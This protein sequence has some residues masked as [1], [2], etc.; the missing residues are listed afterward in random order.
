MLSW[1]FQSNAHIRDGSISVLVLLLAGAALLC[2][3]LR[4]VHHRMEGL[5]E[6]RS[7]AARHRVAIASGLHDGQLN[8]RQTARAATLL[9][10]SGSLALQLALGALAVRWLHALVVAFK[11]LAHRRATGF[12][13]GA[14]GV[15]LSRRAHGLAFRAVF[16]L[17]VVLRAADRAHRTLAVHCALGAGGLLASHFTLGA[18]AHGVAHCRALRVVALPTALGMALLSSNHR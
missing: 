11:F 16:L 6:R 17:T 3:L 1:R 10:A 18:C 9:L 15:A 8:V 14:G 13:G 12:G 7:V 5:N 2:A 4:L